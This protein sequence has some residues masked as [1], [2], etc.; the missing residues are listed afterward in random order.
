MAC[1][2]PQNFDG[3]VTLVDIIIDGTGK[4]SNAVVPTRYGDINFPAVRLVEFVL[5]PRI[6]IV[7]DLNDASVVGAKLSLVSTIIKTDSNSALGG[8][9][10]RQIKSPA[11]PAIFYAILKVGN[12]GNFRNACVS[13]YGD[14]CAIYIAISIC[15]LII[16]ANLTIVFGVGDEAHAAI[17]GDHDIAIVY[18]NGLRSTGQGDT[19]NLCDFQSAVW[20][21]IIA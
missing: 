12:A 4:N 14:I 15:D 6:V 9:N 16:K 1:D 11:H 13:V 17:A 8:G 19:I 20:C 3:L 10:I 7:P 18:R 21:E 2:S 5:C